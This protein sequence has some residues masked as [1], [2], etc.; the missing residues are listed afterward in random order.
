MKLGSL[1]NQML[2]MTLAGGLVLGSFAAFPVE[3]GS[4]EESENIL[5]TLI[6]E[7]SL[8]MDGRDQ[9]ALLNSG[10]AEWTYDEETHELNA[11]LTQG[12]LFFATQ[13]NDWS[14]SV[15]TPFVRVDSQNSTAVLRL[16]ESGESLEVYALEHPSLVTFIS[17]GQDLNSLLVPTG[18]FMKIPSSKIT[19]TLERLR[20]TKLTKEFPVFA[21]EESDLTEEELKVFRASQD[22]YEASAL[23][24]VQ[25]AR[26]GSHFGPP[27]DGIGSVLNSGYSLFEETLTVL[28]SAEQDLSERQTQDYL[29]YGITNLLF[30]ETVVGEQW[31]AQWVAASPNLEEVDELYSALFFVLPGDE[32][33]P[34]KSAASSLLYPEVNALIAL[35]DQYQEIE[36]LLNRGSSVEALSAYQVYQADFELALQSGA[37]DEEELLDE[38]SR[39]YYLLEL[40]LRS[41]AVFYTGDSVQLLAD[42]ETTMLA[43][44]GSDEDLD[45]ERQAFVQSKLRYLANLFDFVMERKISVEDATDLAN[46]LVSDAELYL[47]EITSEVAVKSYFVSKLEEY[48]LSIAFINSAEFAAAEDFAEGLE[49]YKAKEADLDELNEYLQS[50]R[51]N[52][53]S[54]ATLTLEEATSQVKADLQSNGIQFK[55]VESL[56][57][58][59]NR[60]FELLD[61]RTGAY[62]FEAKYDRVTQI[63]YEVLVEDEL[64][65]STGLTLDTAATVIQTAMEEAAFEETLVDDEENIA[66]EEDESS[67]TEEVALARVEAAF[68]EADLKVGAFSF[69][70]VDLEDNTFT[71]EGILTSASLVVSGSYDL[72]TGLA[73]EIV[74]ELDDAIHTLPDIALDQMESALYETYLALTGL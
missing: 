73:T 8:S 31:I 29:V 41:N 5:D 71:F 22:D 50:L 1:V 53:E 11:Q 44:A 54:S 26:E 48:D 21:F 34:L 13:A 2:V 63:L 68:E 61:G 64:R 46:E 55:D 23:K 40:L 57:D 56:G 69:E 20:L 42:L 4:A 72:D 52:D 59:A 37:L 67:L 3:S 16:S 32:L 15:S 24:F 35:R 28:S 38:I 10:L 43:L 33:Y 65:F 25:E 36:S 17:N 7:G 45:E 70:V 12:S 49:A 27:T 74:W 30:G 60:L 47:G 6:N 51:G 18:Y 14:V 39:E 62:H 19:A 58:N 9:V 66:P